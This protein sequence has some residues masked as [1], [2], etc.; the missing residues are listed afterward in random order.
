MSQFICRLQSTAQC[1]P[2]ICHFQTVTDPVY[3][4]THIRKLRIQIR[5][6][7]IAKRSHQRV[8]PRKHALS[9]ERIDN[10]NLPLPVNVSH[11]GIQQHFHTVTVQSFDKHMTAAYFHIRGKS[12][13]QF[14][15]SNPQL[16]FRQNFRRLT[17]HK[18][19][20]EDKNI[21]SDSRALQHLLRADKRRS[22][23]LRLFRLRLS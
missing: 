23:N 9:A 18:P 15:N 19:P 5:I 22:G 13:T 8:I 7:A 4:D 12:V 6:G 10:T 2:H 17:A 16:P 21:L 11:S 14:K 1:H 20:A 3:G